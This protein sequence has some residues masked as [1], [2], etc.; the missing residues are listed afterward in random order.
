MDWTSC[1]QQDENLYI[2]R[3]RAYKSSS[4]SIV[5]VQRRVSE[6]VHVKKINKIMASQNE[7]VILFYSV[8]RL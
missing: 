1:Q 3:V 2:I 4:K 6:S 8:F 7:K 5:D